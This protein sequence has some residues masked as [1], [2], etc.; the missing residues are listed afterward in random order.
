MFASHCRTNAECRAKQPTRA[1]WGVA[2]VFFAAMVAGGWTYAAGQITV[3]PESRLWVEGTSTVRSFTCYAT[4]LEGDIGHQGELGSTIEEV[5]RAVNAVQ[6]DVAASALDCR[7]GT[8]NEHM[9]K[10][11]KA[12]ENP[13]I[14]YRMTSR[15]VVTRPGGGLTINLT[16]MLTLAGREKEIAM[17][18]EAVRDSTG[19]YRVTGSEELRMTDFG[20]K[21]PT[22]MLGTMKVHDKVIVR[23]DILLTPETPPVTAVR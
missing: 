7:N 14:R 16:G 20:I 5:G 17:T 10:A 12:G 3:A 15:E 18:A 4:R 13:V 23:Y 2:L 11:L 8:M 22:L 19:R 9:R 1:R 21:P 6:I